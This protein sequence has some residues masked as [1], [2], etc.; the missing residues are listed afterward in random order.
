M[1]PEVTRLDLRLRRRSVTG[2][3][4]GMAL[5]TFVIVAL[6]PTFK[7]DTGLDA[8]TADGSRVAALFGA[9]GPLTSP[10]GWLSANV[11]ANFL[12]LMVLL[13][14]IGYG[15]HAIAGQDEGGQLGLVAAL[16]VSRRRLVGQKLVALM[17]VSLPTGLTTVAVVLVGRSY[18][19]TVDSGK[20]LAVTVGV[21]LLGVVF[22]ALALL[23]GALTG[24]RGLALGISSALAAASYVVSSLAPV[25]SAIRPLRFVSPFYYAVGDNQLVD[26]PGTGLLVLA[27]LAVI[28]GT[29][30]VVA[31][32]RLDVR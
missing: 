10:T 12:P 24:S 30:A 9:V 25:V 3:A 11:Y 8:L 6:Y 1:L 5:Y 23:I 15:A 7:D 21:V 20:V 13:L 16:P 26:G 18:D 29:A 17:L 19:V 28:I 4:I 22:G 2:Y 31:F 32:E 27:G 14:T